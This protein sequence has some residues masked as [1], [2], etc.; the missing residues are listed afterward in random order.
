MNIF[1]KIF[2]K[3]KFSSKKLLLDENYI[4]S[5]LYKLTNK[6]LSFFKSK[7]KPGQ[8]ICLIL[9]YSI[10]FMA[11]VLSARLNGNIICFINPDSTHS[12]KKIILDQSDYSMVITDENLFLGAQKLGKLYFKTRKNK[13]RLKKEDAFIIFTSGTTSKPKGAILTNTSIKN[14]VLGIIDQLKISLKDRTII[15]SPPNYAMGISQIIT[16]LYTKSSFIFERSGIKFPE[17]FLIKVKKYKI[18]ILNL[19]IAG[20]K[21]IK[22]FIE[23]FR[24]P[25]LRILMSGGMKMTPNNAKEIFDFFGNKY[26]V[27]FYGCTENSPRVSHFKFTK[28]Q[29]S[30]FKELEFLPV[31]KPIKGTKVIIKKSKN[32]DEK[33]YG[34]ILLKGN[35]LMRGYIKKNKKIKNVRNFETKDL[36]FF[37][38]GQ[39]L[40]I[41]GRLDNL[42][43]SGNEKISPE[44]IENK[45]GPYLKRRSFVVIQ[46][47]HPILNWQPVLVIE[48][49]KQK[50]D[51]K[52]IHR[53]EKDLSNFKS[54]KKIFYMKE[55]YRNNYGKIDRKKI[56]N[57]VQK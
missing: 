24:I 44:E 9:P 42:F 55:L 8:I 38:A 27:N 18:S 31:G 54:P 7:I 3:S 52:L 32:S 10:D 50:Y 53:I 1:E 11:I 39:N 19:N 36:G 2:L 40:Y 15:Y 34:E 33:N 25:S 56:F 26:L 20:F 49:K 47:S 37:S 23:K 17:T 45:I 21:Y 4:Y 51:H 12:E 14:N 48:G 35:S 22:N 16:F 41:I 6:Y 30:K 13:R 5:D 28:N 57:R 29:L 46:K 43:K